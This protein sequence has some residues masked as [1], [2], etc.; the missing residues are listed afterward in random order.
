MTQVS[1]R[2][3]ETVKSDA[4]SLFSNLGM[5]LSTAINVFLRQSIVQR[6]LPFAVREDPF[7]SEANQAHLERAAADYERG[8]NFSRHELVDIADGQAVAR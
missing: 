8:A 3:D 6:G 1:F 7:W 2:I 5:S 4:E